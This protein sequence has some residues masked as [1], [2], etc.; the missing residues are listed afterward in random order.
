MN[1]YL[2]PEISLLPTTLCCFLHSWVSSDFVKYFLGEESYQILGGGKLPR[3]KSIKYR[4]SI[5]SKQTKY[6][7]KSSRAKSKS[8]WNSLWKL[9]IFLSLLLT[10]AKFWTIEI[11]AFILVFHSLEVFIFYKLNNNILL[12]L[13]L[14]HLQGQT[15][16]GSWFYV[17]TID[18]THKP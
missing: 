14:K 13:N 12:R 3:L 4:R 15:Q 7:L 5:Q 16:K 2:I 18:A 6:K 10:K 8:E 11:E 17:A 9:D 1:L